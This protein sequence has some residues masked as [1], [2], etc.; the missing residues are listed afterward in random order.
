MILVQQTAI[1]ALLEPPVPLALQDLVSLMGLA[2]PLALT[3]TFSRTQT[4]V[5]SVI[6]YV[7]SVLL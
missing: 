6:P 3:P 1:C 4:P 7:L 2:I 5:L